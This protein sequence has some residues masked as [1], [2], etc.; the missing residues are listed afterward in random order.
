MA[1][2]IHRQIEVPLA[3]T[4]SLVDLTLRDTLTGW[5]SLTTVTPA[6]A[7]VIKALLKI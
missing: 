7:V 4:R 3:L 1:Y 6:H 2:R 5:L